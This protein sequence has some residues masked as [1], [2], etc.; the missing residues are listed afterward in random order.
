MIGGAFA[1]VNNQ[2]PQSGAKFLELARDYNSCNSV[3]GA[4]PG[5]CQ[6]FCDEADKLV[7]G[8]QVANG[9]CSSDQIRSIQASAIQQGRSEGIQQ[10][11]D[12]VLRDL[13]I[14]EDYISVDYYG[15][16]QD[17][18]ARRANMAVQGLR[19]EAIQR[20]NSKAA[21]IKNCYIS[22]EKVTGSDGRPPRFE[23]SAQFRREDNRSTQEECQ[24]S[25]L[26]DATQQAL[27]KC[28]AS[29]G[30]ECVISASET[31]LTHRL[32]APG[33]LRMGR[34]D[35]RI[36]DAKVIAD[37]PRDLSYKCNMRVSAR[38]QAFAN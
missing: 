7:N 16:N 30:S 13:S 36:C 22:A 11:R 3:V 18:C 37:A 32:Q 21:S 6:R 4:D 26:N 19:L 38:N 12:E 10:G 25:A 33:G 8:G 34:R 2:C 35:D 20:C 15:I 5:A 23:G 9:Q 17:D 31:I 14:K 27:K 1:Q 24:K 28:M 29:T